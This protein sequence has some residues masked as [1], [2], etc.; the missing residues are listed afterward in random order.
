MPYPTPPAPPQYYVDN[1]Y[2][3]PSMTT[4]FIYVGGEGPLGGTP[5]GYVSELAQRHSACIVALEHRWY[6]DSVPGDVGSTADLRT[7]SV[8]QA[9]A[10]LASFLTWYDAQIGGAV[11]A[12]ARVGGSA[13]THTWLVIGGS[14]PGALSSWFRELHPELV[15]ASWSSSGVVEAVYNFTRF[16]QI[17]AE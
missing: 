8:E 12:T 7:L 2:Y 3:N 4:C 10:D 1:T 15:A 17:V 14:Y 13:V 16:D 6:G 9:I 5:A 11:A